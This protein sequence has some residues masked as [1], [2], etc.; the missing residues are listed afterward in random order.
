MGYICYGI[1]L[2]TLLLFHWD[3]Y[4]VDSSFQRKERIIKGLR[5]LFWVKINNQKI[6]KYL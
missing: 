4:D 6:T 3:L 2:I 5:Y 1:V